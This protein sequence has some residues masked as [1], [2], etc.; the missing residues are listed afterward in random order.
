V[1]ELVKHPQ[2][3]FINVRSMEILKSEVPHVYNGILSDMPNVRE[4][5]CFNFG[6]C[7]DMSNGGGKRLAT[8]IHPVRHLL[9]VGQRGDAILV[10]DESDGNNNWGRKKLM[11]VMNTHRM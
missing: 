11:Q 5:E 3:H 9:R 6:G 2:A 4:W 1:E 10:P 7:V 8:V